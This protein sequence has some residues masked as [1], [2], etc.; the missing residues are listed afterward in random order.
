MIRA[1]DIAAVGTVGMKKAVVGVNCSI[2]HARGVVDDA[3]ELRAAHHH[4]GLVGSGIL[5][6]LA[7]ELRVRKTFLNNNIL[8]HIHQG[9]GVWAAPQ[10]HFRAYHAHTL[11]RLNLDM[12]WHICRHVGNERICDSA[13]AG[14]VAG[15]ILQGDAAQAVD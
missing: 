7:V 11:E 15:M 8:Y 14:A 5:D 13:V 6:P 10:G 2:S 9:R 4:V 12:V 3:V 1:V